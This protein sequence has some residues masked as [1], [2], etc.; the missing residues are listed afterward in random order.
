MKELKKL[1]PPNPWTVTLLS[2][3][4]P[5]SL[6]LFLALSP[7]GNQEQVPTEQDPCW[8]LTDRIQEIL[9]RDLSEHIMHQEDNPGFKLKDWIDLRSSELVEMG[10]VLDLTKQEAVDCLE[11]MAEALR[12]AV[13]ELQEEIDTTERNE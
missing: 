8:F 2:L 13:T 6:F 7:E 4:F 10:V 12:E 11:Y 9:L 5:L 3:L 1:L